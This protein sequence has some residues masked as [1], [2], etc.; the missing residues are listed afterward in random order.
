MLGQ[1]HTETDILMLKSI[2]EGIYPT[3]RVT[4][5]VS[6]TSGFTSIELFAGA[7]GTALGFENAGFSHVLV[8]EID[9]HAV[10]T[11]IHNRPQWNVVKDDVK[12]ISFAQYEGVDVLVAGFPC[13][14]FSMAGNRKGFADTRGT[15]FHEVIRAARECHPK[16]IVGE[17]VKGLVSH[18]K[19][20]T[21]NVICSA[22]E[23]AGYIPFWK[24]LRAQ[25]YGVA[26]KRERIILV[27]VR[28]DLHDS[29]IEPVFPQEK[30]VALT[31]KEALHDVP[32]SEGAP[33][34]KGKQEMFSLIPEGGNW[35][36]LPTEEWK[37]YALGASYG[38]GAGG[39]TGTA[40]KLAWNEP[41]LTVMCSPSQRQTERCHPEEIRPLTVRESARVQSFPDSWEFQGS[42]TQQY[43]QIGNAVPVN[44]AY[45]AAMMVRDMLEQYTRR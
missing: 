11:L 10:N 1:Q 5:P 15:L 7:G 35:T 27:G 42:R 2:S 16:I 22:L 40:R 45:H 30:G 3:G 32:D 36:D 34:P 38:S 41:C 13:Q 37:K 6:S 43:K 29:G 26:Q 9:S 23:D 21:L 33:Y 39:K 44:L 25:F 20:T 31:L 24:I 28:K 19:G 4:T 18:D 14:T 17:N 8:N 12:N